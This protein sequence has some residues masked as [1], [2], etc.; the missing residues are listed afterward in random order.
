MLTYPNSRIGI[1]VLIF[2]Y[3]LII[4]SY[5]NMKFQLLRTQLLKLLFVLALDNL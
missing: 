4:V 5:S 1:K 3:S 2:L